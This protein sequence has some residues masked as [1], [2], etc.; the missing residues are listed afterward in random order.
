[1]TYYM[2]KFEKIRILGA[3]ATQI[4]EGAPSTIC[5]CGL[6]NAMEIA[7][8]ELKEHKLPLMIQRR[9]PNGKVIEIPV[10]DMKL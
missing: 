4:S 6:T 8:K 9:Y 3:R 1:M 7:K 10:S 5:T 2:T